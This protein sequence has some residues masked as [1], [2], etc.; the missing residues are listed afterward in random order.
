M[1]R[2]RKTSTQPKRKPQKIVEKPKPVYP[3]FIQNFI[4]EIESK[5]PFKVQVDQYSKDSAY[6]VGVLQKQSKI[7]RCIWML[8]YATNSEELGMF[9]ASDCYKNWSKNGI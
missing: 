5:T 9:W 7:Y 6:H 2:I 4:S 8:N 1:P 3:E